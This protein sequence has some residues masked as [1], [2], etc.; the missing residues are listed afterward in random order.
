MS[1]V[2]SIINSRSDV[3]LSASKLFFCERNYK[4]GNK[5]FSNTELE[6]PHTL[7]DNESVLKVYDKD[8]NGFMLIDLRANKIEFDEKFTYFLLKIRPRG[9]NVLFITKRMSDVPKILI[10]MTDFIIKPISFRIL[11]QIPFS[12][13]RL[14]IF[15]NLEKRFMKSY[16]LDKYV[17]RVKKNKG[18]A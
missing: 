11:R 3:L 18:R 14:D 17:K 1:G 7:V 13:Y 10:K 9:I 15:T 6:Y 16:I 4:K 5:L 12:S 8:N 2:I